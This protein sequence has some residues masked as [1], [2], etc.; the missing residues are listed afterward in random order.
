MFW[1]VRPIAK[2]TFLVLWLLLTWS[3]ERWCPGHFVYFGAYVPPFLPLFVCVIHLWYCFTVASEEEN[4]P[5]VRPSSGSESQTG[6]KTGTE[7]VG[8]QISRSPLWFITSQTFF[9]FQFAF[10]IFNRDISQF[11]FRTIFGIVIDVC[12]F[13]LPLVMLSVLSPL[14]TK[15]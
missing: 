1:E 13:Q 11:D 8:E 5:H 3:G 4:N 9:R 15:S 10:T 14:A 6:M 12:A 7:G 2:W